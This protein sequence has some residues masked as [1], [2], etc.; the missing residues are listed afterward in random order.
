MR[1]TFAR[2]ALFGAL[3]LAPC[4]SGASA[5]T[6]FAT[7]AQANS[8]NSISGS[9][10]DYKTG[11]GQINTA[12]NTSDA[13]GS[14]TLSSFAN[15]SASA[16]G[17]AIKA[18]AAAGAGVV[19]AGN[20][21]A[22]GT[23]TGTLNDVFSVSCPTC[24][25]G[26]RGTMTFAVRVDGVLGGSGLTTLSGPDGY[27]TGAWNGFGEWSFNLSLNTTA[28]P[29]N[30]GVGNANLSKMGSRFIDHTGSDISLGDSFGTF[31]LTVPV[32]FG[33]NNFLSLYG[34]ASARANA[35]GFIAGDGGFVSAQSQY[36]AD[37]SH[38]FAWGGITDLRDESGN[39]I[40][41][42]TAISDGSGFDYA[43]AFANPTGA[44]PEPG[45]WALM[46][47]GFGGVGSALRHRARR[48]LA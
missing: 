3:V 4:A 26:G 32:V 43:K 23:A 16:Q 46:I 13:D 41:D 5:A 1:N 38:T 7:T 11:A 30:G 35:G 25:Y 28:P 17:G 39:R 44:V 6:T 40:T 29:A 10:D 12:T 14:S 2:S 18:Q 42:F 48:V 22:V 21:S 15:A 37:L 33:G 19:G 31:L 45:A 36:S 9:N 8:Y 34:Y 24:A 47:L 20:A 27:A